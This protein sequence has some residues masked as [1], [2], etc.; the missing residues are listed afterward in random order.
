M[1]M[2]CF[3]LGIYNLKICGVGAVK[4]RLWRFPSRDFIESIF[5]VWQPN[6]VVVDVNSTHS[7][8]N[9]GFEITPTLHEPNNL[10]EPN[11]EQL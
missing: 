9:M 3:I 5:F 1:G 10:R 8:Y 2:F 4:I 7:I 11:I 6:S